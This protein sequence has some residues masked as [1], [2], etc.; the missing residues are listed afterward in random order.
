MHS[1]DA[2]KERLLR[3]LALCS[4]SSR[5]RSSEALCSPV[6]GWP[7]AGV[8]AIASVKICGRMHGCVFT[9]RNVVR[10]RRFRFITLCLSIH[11]RLLLV[12]GTTFTD[13]QC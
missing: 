2:K 10:N 12:G 11:G 1:D 7:P 9:F 8:F 3:R 13:V 6:P 5:G 4:P